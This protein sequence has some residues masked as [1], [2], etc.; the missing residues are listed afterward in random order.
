MINGVDVITQATIVNGIWSA[1]IT[2]PQ[3]GINWYWV[4]AIPVDTDKC[5]SITL[6][7]YVNY[8]PV[9]V[10]DDYD[11]VCDDIDNCV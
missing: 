11:G 6:D 3:T 9:C 8:T 10:D 5:A 1:Q 4:T 2:L 7:G